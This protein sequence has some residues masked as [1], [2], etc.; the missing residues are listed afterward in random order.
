MGYLYAAIFLTAIITKA[1][2]AN[3]PEGLALW[4]LGDYIKTFGLLCIIKAFNLNQ[5]EEE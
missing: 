1:I 4:L 5:E 3:K 2:T